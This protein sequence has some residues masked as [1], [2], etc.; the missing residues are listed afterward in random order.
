MASYNCPPDIRT[1]SLIGHHRR[2]RTMRPRHSIRTGSPLDQSERNV[3][4][5][6]HHGAAVGRAPRPG[7]RT[8]SSDSPESGSATGTDFATQQSILRV[9]RDARRSARRGSD[10]QDARYWPMSNVLLSALGV[11]TTSLLSTCRPRRRNVLSID[12]YDVNTSDFPFV[13]ASLRLHAGSGSR[14]GEACDARRMARHGR[15]VAANRSSFPVRV[16]FHTRWKAP[17][18]AVMPW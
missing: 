16:S 17:A 4:L 1:A 8:P 9:A 13:A 7:G 3:R 5:L 10:Q 11:S 2:P 14:H 15:T 12:V 6:G 18:L